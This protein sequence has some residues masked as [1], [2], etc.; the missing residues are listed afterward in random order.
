MYKIYLTNNL[1]GLKN[2]I[3]YIKGL[4]GVLRINLKFKFNFYIENN[5]FIYK[6]S[7]NYTTF[8]KNAMLGSNNFF[9]KIIELNGLGF[10]FLKFENSILN[11]RLGSSVRYI[12]LDKKLD[13]NILNKE[14]TKI[15]LKGIDRQ[16][17]G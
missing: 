17:V 12:K 2:N 1:I 16:K 5:Y 14:G 8:I 3:L 15:E 9:S 11:I 10:K 13:V 6:S 7:F 4:L